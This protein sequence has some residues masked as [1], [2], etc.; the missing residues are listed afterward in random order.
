MRELGLDAANFGT[1]DWNPFGDI[2]K[3]SQVVVLKPNLVKHFHPMGDSYYLSTV[4]HASVLR[5]LIDYAAKALNGRGRII[6]ADTPLDYA[7]FDRVAA[8]TGIA[9]LVEYCRQNLDVPVELLDLREKRVFIDE[10]AHRT[11]TDLPGDPRGYANIDL[12]H[13]SAL[14]DLDSSPQNYYTLADDTVDHLNPMSTAPGQTNRYHYPGHHEYRISKT[15]LAAETIIYV[16]KLKTHKKAGVTL[17]LKNSIGIVG[18]KVYMPHHRPGAPPQGDAFPVP[19][20][21]QFLLKR[22]LYLAMMRQTAWGPR[23]WEMVRRVKRLLASGPEPSAESLKEREPIEWGD[24][25]GNDT[26]WRSILDLNRILIYAD[27]NG[28]MQEAPQRAYLTVLDGIIG[29]EGEGPMT[30]IP[31][32]CGIVLAGTNPVAVDMAAVRAMGFNSERIPLM[33]N[34]AKPSRY[35]LSAFPDPL[36]ELHI[37][38]NRPLPAL[39]FKPPRGWKDLCVESV[40]HSGPRSRVIAPRPGRLEPA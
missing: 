14:V 28:R 37:S 6:I 27:S 22:S 34:A 17:S 2:V 35:R 36:P 38:G 11:V 9:D 24:W 1:Q 40:S 7:D 16:P 19:P 20:P 13:D 15:I 26:I 5:P 21:R 25:S 3:P 29:Q 39:K 32:P 4:T 30:G 23:V 10:A 8:L 33:T 12:G 31:K 18:G